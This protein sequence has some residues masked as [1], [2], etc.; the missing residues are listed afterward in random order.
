MAVEKTS[1]RLFDRVSY[2]LP[3]VAD[4]P[5]GYGDDSS[6]KEL[7]IREATLLRQAVSLCRSLLNPRERYVAAYF[8]AVRTLLTRIVGPG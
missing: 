7:F 3:K 6:R 5:I 2:T 4:Q 1:D 8:D